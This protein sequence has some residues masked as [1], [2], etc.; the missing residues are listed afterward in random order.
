MSEMLKLVQPDTQQDVIS[1][2]EER[3][4]Q[5][6]KGELKAVAILAMYPSNEIDFRVS[7][8]GFRN[9]C[10]MLGALELLKSGL[11]KHTWRD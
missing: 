9:A 10:Q 7:V 1:L 2:L 4:N 11:I 5:A 3:L 8:C 6:K